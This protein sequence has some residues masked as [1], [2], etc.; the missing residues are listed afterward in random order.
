VRDPENK[1]D[2]K[3]SSLTF[4]RNTP[5]FLPI[6]RHRIRGVARQ[7]VVVSRVLGVYVSSG[8]FSCDNDQ[9]RILIEFLMPDD[10][11]KDQKFRFS[12]KYCRQSLLL[13]QL[14]FSF[15][16]ARFQAISG[17]SKWIFSQM[18]TEIPFYDE[19]R[20]SSGLIISQAIEK[21]L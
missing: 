10:D 8:Q 3:L 13:W 2:D 19:V 21:S 1:R 12:E 9:K 6:L 7:E 15:L 4:G 18:R 16:G 11:M 5:E 17:N 14:L 20:K